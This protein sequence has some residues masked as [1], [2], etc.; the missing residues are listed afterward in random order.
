VRKGAPRN[1]NPRRAVAVS[2]EVWRRVKA[3]A[4]VFGIS[5]NDWLEMILRREFEME[6]EKVT[7]VTE[8]IEVDQ[9][10]I[11]LLQDSQGWY[12]GTRDDSGWRFG[13]A[14]A[15]PIEAIKALFT[16]VLFPGKEVKE[17]IGSIM[18]PG[19][20]RLKELEKE[21]HNGQDDTEARLP[22]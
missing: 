5:I 14:K 8:D 6:E 13:P 10:E 15:T 3:E 16:E 4:A 9:A 21:G 22:D 19:Y 12:A 1:E 17:S 2:D 18:S 20:A 7:D 11:K